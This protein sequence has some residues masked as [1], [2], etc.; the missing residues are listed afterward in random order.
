MNVTQNVMIHELHWLQ[1]IYL[2]QLM[3]IESW[4][5]NQ[6]AGQ[7]VT[8]N[9]STFFFPSFADTDL[10]FKKNGTFE[11]VVRGSGV[12]VIERCVGV[13]RKLW[14]G[15]KTDRVGSDKKWD[16]VNLDEKNG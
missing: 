12:P 1:T 13:Y 6:L 10:T 7:F 2:H 9:G 5:A 8:K 15:W 3:A 16:R 11:Y 14:I 4:L